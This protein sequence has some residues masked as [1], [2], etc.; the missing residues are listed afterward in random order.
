[1]ISADCGATFLPTGYEKIGSALST[2]ADSPTDWFP[3]SGSQWRRDTV[4][5]TPWAGQFV[6]L[7]FVNINDYGNNILL[8]N[9]QLWNDPFAGIGI[10]ESGT[11][12]GVYPN[13][14]SGVFRLNATGFS[15]GL[16]KLTVL[17]ALGRL[18]FSREVKTSN[19]MLLDE[20]DLRNQSPGIYQAI[21]STT[22]GEIRSRLVRQ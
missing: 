10:A 19:G 6:I 9:V 17:D 15:E 11:T 20:V 21:V 22:K 16:C 13:P 14:S 18:V 1:M 3:T 2:T 12:I 7:K 8:D 5:L 4:D